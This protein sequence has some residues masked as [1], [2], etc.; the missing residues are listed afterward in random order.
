MHMWDMRFQPSRC[1]KNYPCRPSRISWYSH[2]FRMYWSP[3]HHVRE[4]WFR[5]LRK[6]DQ[7]MK[8]IYR[9]LGNHCATSFYSSLVAIER[10]LTIYC[11]L[12]G[13]RTLRKDEYY[14]TTADANKQWL[15]TCNDADGEHREFPTNSV[16]IIHHCFYVER[17]PLQSW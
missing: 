12:N 13:N 5:I 2:V 6:R 10:E 14:P 15:F 17:I 9:L 7:T 3:R 8:Y 4:I 16:E 11:E 1:C